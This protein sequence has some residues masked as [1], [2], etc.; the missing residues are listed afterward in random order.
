M[1]LS[2][3]VKDLKP[4]IITPHMEEVIKANP[5]ARA[6]VIAR[7]ILRGMVKQRGKIDPIDIIHNGEVQT[8]RFLDIEPLCEGPW[9]V[10]SLLLLNA[11]YGEQSVIIEA[12]YPERKQLIAKAFAALF[13]HDVPEVPRK[14]DTDI[15][16]AVENANAG[17]AMILA[18]MDSAGSG[19]HA[20]EVSRQRTAMQQLAKSAVERDRFHKGYEKYQQSVKKGDQS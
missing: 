7:Y 9:A 5:A 17:I 16:E 11:S 14:K 4:N 2:E 1:D 20:D 19:I 12:L 18:K 13:S 10:Y 8:V 6:N 15:L 3:L